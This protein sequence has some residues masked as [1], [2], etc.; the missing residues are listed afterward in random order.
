L[1]KTKQLYNKNTQ[2]EKN[3]KHNK[4]KHALRTATSQKEKEHV[5]RH[6]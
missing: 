4:P 5:R 3:D 2:G 6:V 1:S